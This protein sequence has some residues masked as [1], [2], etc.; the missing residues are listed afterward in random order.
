MK[1]V[2]A[3]NLVWFK[4]RLILGRN[5]SAGFP[6]VNF[7]LVG[8]EENGEGDPLGTPHVLA[9]LH[10]DS[11]YQPGLL[12]A[13]ERTGEKGSELW[14]EICTQNRGV[15]RFD[16]LAHAQRSHSGVAGASASL[17][18]RIYRAYG[19]LSKLLQSC[20]T[21]HSADGW[22]SQVAFPF[23]QVGTPGIYN[24]TAAE[25]RLGVE[26]RPIP[27]DDPIALAQVVQNYCAENDLE[28]QVSVMQNGITC[29]PDN[30]YLSLLV[31]AVRQASGQ[32]PVIGRKLPGTSARF[33]PGDQGVVWGQSGIG[34]HSANE[35]HYVPSILPY[36]QAL[37]SYAELLNKV[38][39]RPG[40]DS[41]NP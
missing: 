25:A 15:M 3:T 34:P 38:D 32:S 21:L 33:A 10:A 29:A 36:Y 11:G 39:S 6:P 16:V 30:P 7:L 24:V 37:Q 31:Q 1:T 23:I 5:S 19:D 13:G 20:L 12:I 17:S 40:K 41:L 2:L 26:V 4:D 27:Q 35:R 18:D 8:N 9:L 14:G 22:Q 28:L